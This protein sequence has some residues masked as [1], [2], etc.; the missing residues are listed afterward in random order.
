MLLCK[1]TKG[2][3]DSFLVD[4]GLSFEDTDERLC[5]FLKFKINIVFHDI[6]NLSYYFFLFLL[7][8]FVL[9]VVGDEFGQQSP[10]LPDLGLIKDPQCQKFS[11]C[12]DIHIERTIH[13]FIHN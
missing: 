6:E 10:E 4:I 7:F 11:Q 8:R 9:D 5:D 3:E 13:N 1:S 12:L 2:I